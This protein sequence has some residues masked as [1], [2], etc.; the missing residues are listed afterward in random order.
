MVLIEMRWACVLCLSYI[1]KTTSFHLIAVNVGRTSSRRAVS[2]W[3]ERNPITQIFDAHVFEILV[4]NSAISV[5]V[6][7]FAHRLAVVRVG[8]VGLG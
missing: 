8:L 7:H 2:R 5:C 1:L 3:T 6:E 4:S